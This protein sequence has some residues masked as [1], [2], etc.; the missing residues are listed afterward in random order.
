MDA[1]SFDKPFPLESLSPDSFERFCHHLLNL[2]Y[3][4]AK[5]NRIGT[6]GHTQGGIDIEAI[7]DNGDICHYQ[8]KRH[9][10][11]GPEKVLRTI[12]DYK[13]E[14][15]NKVILLARVATPD[16]RETI[17]KFFKDG[18][19][20]HDVDDISLFVRSK[21]SKTDQIKIVD[22]YFPGLRHQLLGIKNDDVWLSTEEFFQ[23]FSDINRIFN[24]EWPLVA[25]NETITNIEKAFILDKKFIS[26]LVGAG[27]SGKTRI[28]KAICENLKINEPKAKIYIASP[29]TEITS[30]SINCLEGNILYVIIDDAHDRL[31]LKYVYHK[32]TQE[33]NIK[34]ILSLRP[35]GEESLV[36]ELTRFGI[37]NSE[38]HLEHLGGL[39]EKQATHLA[40]SVLRTHNGP[41]DLAEHVA[42]LTYDCPLAT[43]IGAYIVAKENVNPFLINSEDQ[44]R[45][46]I[47]SRFEKIIAGEIGNP[48]EEQEIRSILQ[49]IALAQ[50]IY[51]EDENLYEIL[52]SVNNV[53]PEKAK[54]YLHNLH[55]AG[56]LIKRGLK[57]RLSP[58]P[59]G[60]FLIEK[61]CLGINGISTGYSDKVLEHASD[62]IAENIIINIGKMD[63]RL[64]NQD[65]S[66][67]NLLDASWRKLEEKGGVER[68]EKILTS[69]AYYQPQ[70]ALNYVESQICKGIRN[71]ELARICK[72]VAY[73]QQHVIHACECLW[74]L[75]RGDDRPLNQHSNHP[76]RIL[77]EI[78][79]IEP[80]KPIEYNKLLSNYFITLLNKNESWIRA[81]TPL[82]IIQTLLETESHTTTSRGHTF[83]FH[84]YFVN[85]ESV[86]FLRTSIIDKLLLVIGGIDTSRACVA[87]KAIE[88]AL[89]Y[90][91]SH[92]CPK[93][94]LEQWTDE[95]VSIFIKLKNLLLHANVH[96]VVWIDILRA[97]SWHEKFSNTDTRDAAID[98]ANQAPK[99]FFFEVTLALADGEGTLS[100]TEDYQRSLEDWADYIYH[101]AKSLT[102][103]VEVEGILSFIESIIKDI[104]KSPNYALFNS[105]NFIRALIHIYPGFASKVIRTCLEHD[106]SIFFTYL[107]AAIGYLLT[108]DKGFAHRVITECLLSNNSHV[109]VCVATAYAF[110]VD[111]NYICDSTD[112]LNFE[113]LL[114][115]TH[116]N[117]VKSAVYILQQNRVQDCAKSIKLLLNANF[118]INHKTASQALSFLFMNNQK[119][120]KYID[121]DQIIEIFSKLTYL[122]TLSDYWI[123]KFIELTSG[124]YAKETI[125]FL[126]KFAENNLITRGYFIADYSFYF[127][128]KTFLFRNSPEFQQLLLH[129][130]RW[131]STNINNKY[132]IE[133]G[134]DIF[135]IVSGPL[136]SELIQFISDWYKSAPAQEINA[137][138]ELLGKQRP[139]FV[140]KNFDFV[141]EFLS[142]SYHLGINYHENALSSLYSSAVSG[143]YE[144]TFGQ[145]TAKDI[146]L[147]DNSEIAISKLSRFDPAYTLY[148]KLLEHAVED[149]NRTKLEAE[150]F[151]E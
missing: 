47:L 28:L 11:F 89:H 86:K 46:I 107:S 69:V 96:Y 37:S 125:D 83:Q 142:F 145:P 27:G 141:V 8:C 39:T 23:P 132:R 95:F 71:E 151:E 117:V 85:L 63:W 114:S 104:S 15:K 112:L 18:W 84:S 111:N 16:A 80:N 67:A 70:R 137:I 94:I 14:A 126:F 97:I 33:R 66:C 50:P 87:V 98:L 3:P 35:Y 24:H 82:E 19:L 7:F 131:I 147:R 115:S 123:Y 30:D 149:I 60:D 105:Y 2:L 13:K 79:A 5:V 73:N 103:V 144:G 20:L 121:R 90:P 51:I 17:K 136:D 48:G 140:F 62:V 36:N 9:K 118:N 68:I 41:S 101:L 26:I 138:S 4:E 130:K 25:R 76:I 127:S 12:S 59:L 92:G 93:E 32:Y 122:E 143:V 148:N 116:E 10:N 134:V 42:S 108:S 128:K 139:D 120:L 29:T 54:I 57:Y 34:I 40:E 75:S 38:F 74:E 91:I 81:Y 109:L 56:V 1:T 31:D 61:S 58:D 129:I 135:C 65:K 22:V 100:E 110:S 52:K 119:I 133:I 49:I 106:D 146:S 6:Q 53:M 77:K 43:V 44:F 78:S 99:T 113:I 21:L 150:A 55:N 45:R 124:A 64:R 102:S 72:Y 88:H